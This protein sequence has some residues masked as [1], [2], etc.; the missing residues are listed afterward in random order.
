MKRFKF[1]AKG[2]NSLKLQKEVCPIRAVISSAA[3]RP[4]QSER[5]LE[6]KGM[7][8]QVFI[9]SYYEVIKDNLI[10]EAHDM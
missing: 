4:V 1:C 3:F 5:K 7:Q 6:I 10:T 8:Q 9:K 2:L